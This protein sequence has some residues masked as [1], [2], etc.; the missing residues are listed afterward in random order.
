VGR[1]VSL[2]LSRDLGLGHTQPIRATPSFLSADPRRTPFSP[3]SS[4]AEQVKASRGSGPP[5]P[6]KLE[7][8][9]LR[10]CRL[11]GVST[12]KFE[13]L[14]R[15]ISEH[16]VVLGSVEDGLPG[17]QHGC[18]GEHLLGPQHYY[19]DASIALA[20][21]ES[22]GSSTIRRRQPA[23][24]QLTAAVEHTEGEQ[25]TG[26]EEGHRRKRAHGSIPVP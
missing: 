3:S 4:Q 1:P 8:P 20:T 14:S 26:L 23:L 12:L 9:R 11:T 7:A 15:G 25:R 21:M 22:I 17:R 13:A 5:C 10:R 16:L 2:I 24:G 6:P 18:D 19:S